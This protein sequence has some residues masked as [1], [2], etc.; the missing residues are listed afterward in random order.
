MGAL[1]RERGGI[2]LAVWL[3]VLLLLFAFVTISHFRHFVWP[4]LSR[5]QWRVGEGFLEIHRTFLG[6][7]WV[8]QFADARLEVAIGYG[9]FSARK[10]IRARLLLHAPGRRRTLWDSS[11]WS[12]REI[13]GL[14]EYLAARTGWTLE[15]PAD[16]S[17][18]AG[19]GFGGIR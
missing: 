1:L 19:L 16:V 10:G 14:G 11:I 9:W 8:E 5:M 17:V 2:L 13:R 12:F 15:G 3:V 7:Q 4:A 18:L 6:R